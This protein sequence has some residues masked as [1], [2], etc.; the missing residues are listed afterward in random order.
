MDMLPAANC[1]RLRLQ[2]TV[3]P[4]VTAGP[5]S[6]ALSAADTAPLTY[7]MLHPGIKGN[8]FSVTVPISISELLNV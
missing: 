4:Y 1:G 5:I 6:P 2:P 7:L 3:T 8:L